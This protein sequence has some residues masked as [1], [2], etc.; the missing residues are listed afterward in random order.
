MLV[1]RTMHMCA[2]A[3][4]C[5]R[6]GNSK[7][8]HVIM[9]L[10]ASPYISK[11]SRKRNISKENNYDEGEFLMLLLTSEC[12][13][14]K[15]KFLKQNFSSKLSKVDYQWNFTKYFTRPHRLLSGKLHTTPL[16]F[17]LS[18]SLVPVHGCN[19]AISSDNCNA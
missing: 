8:L 13:F 4:N 10:Y 7:Y 11:S 19:L 3:N 1:I 16:K 5:W 15:K 17:H 18:R 2:C 6:R 14:T 12:N 9:M